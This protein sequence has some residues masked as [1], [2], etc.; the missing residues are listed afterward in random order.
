MLSAAV[1]GGDST[2]PG[3][4]GAFPVR[5]PLNT[6][7]PN[8]GPAP[9]P[10]P[11]PVMPARRPPM[12]P[13]MRPIRA[14]RHRRRSLTPEIVIERRSGGHRSSGGG[15]RVFTIPLDHRPT[16]GLRGP[17]RRVLEIER[18][19]CYRRRR[20]RSYC[21]D[22]DYYPAP[23]QPTS[24]IVV[25]NP[26]ANPCLP[27]VQAVPMSSATA[28]IHNLTPA[29]IDNLP[30]QTVHLPPIHL[31]GSQADANTE[32]YTVL[33]PAEIINPIDGTLSVIQGNSAAN[34]GGMMNMQ[35]QMMRPAQ[36]LGRPMATVRPPLSPAMAADPLMQRFSDLFQR[37]SIP[38]TQPVSQPATTAPLLQPMIPNPSPIRPNLPLIRPTAPTMTEFDPVSTTA[39]GSSGPYPPAN[40]R[41]TNMFNPSAYRPSTVTPYR[42]SSFTPSVPT[43]NNNN[44]YRPSNPVPSAPSDVGPYRPANITPYANRLATNPSS[45]PSS[46]TPY[47]PPSSIMSS[48]SFNSLPPLS[49]PPPPP[50]LPE[51]VQ[52]SINPVP[53]SILRNPLPSSAYS[54]FNRASAPP[55]K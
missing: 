8:V 52:S 45:G 4:Y 28:L 15:R 32:L 54:I 51:V 42:P 35:P 31:P 19:R 17:S 7:L 50:P 39:S 5:P 33:F 10:F 11:R 49:P 27:A 20:C 48:S 36:T 24:N 43:N 44:I 6:P 16:L 3:D 38:Q 12:G 21:Y 37:L 29:A 22:D 41:P 23:V 34:I 2:M 30:K 46:S 55:S 13:P 18:V 26:I 25:A 1:N 40:I 53:R 9:R 14:R 47:A